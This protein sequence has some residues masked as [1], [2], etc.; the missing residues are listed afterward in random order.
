MTLTVSATVERWPVA[1]EFIIS[2]GAKKHV[3][4]VLCE[5]S[6]GTHS[7]AA[8]AT[9]IY[10]EGESAGQCV[11]EITRF[12]VRHPDLDRSVLLQN[13]ARGAARNALDCAL[14]NL[15]CRK[16]AKGGRIAGTCPADDSFYDIAWS[17]GDYGGTRPAGR[18]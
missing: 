10:Y 1:G 16:S 2:R 8:E 6:D 7:G 18:R 12:A 3:D 15:E 5:I 4:V 13:M 14:W 11:E 9:P 17:A